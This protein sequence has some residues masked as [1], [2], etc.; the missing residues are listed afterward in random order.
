MTREWNAYRVSDALAALNAVLRPDATL[1]DDRA[2]G[3]HLDALE[4]EGVTEVSGSITRSG[5]PEL[6]QADPA[7][8]ATDDDM[9]E[10][11]RMSG[12][13]GECPEGMDYSRWLAMN[14]VD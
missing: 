9:A 14:N 12:Y 13:P 4:R 5:R 6:V 1:G 8:F 2:I 3:A 11:Q 7:W 10:C